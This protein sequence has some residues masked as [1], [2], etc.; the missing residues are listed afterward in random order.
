MTD[1]DRTTPVP[2]APARE[3]DGGLRA[4]APDHCAAPGDDA[5]PTGAADG[6]AD[7]TD[8]VGP[9]AA[10]S[11]DSVGPVLGVPGRPRRDGA[12]P[13]GT[14]DDAGSA[15]VAEAAPGASA[16]AG[17]TSATAAGASQP[18]AAPDRG[19]A[20]P[21][22]AAGSVPASAAGS[23]ADTTDPVGPVL[24]VPDLALVVLVGPSGS[25]KSVFAA[26]HFL[27]TEVV[28]SDRCRAAV[29]D[30]PTDQSATPDAFALLDF[31]VRTRLRRG[32]LT[33]VDATSVQREARAALLRAAKD[34]DVPAAAIVF[35]VPES[36]SQA[37]NAERTD[38]APV[39]P[40][41]VTRQARDLRRGLKRLGKE[42]FRRVHVLRGADEADAARVVRERSWND[43]KDLTGPFD[44]IGDVHGCRAEL[45]ELLGEL[46][47]TVHR[48][49]DGRAVG[50]RHP[51]GRTAV[52]VGDL[53]DR[54]PD[55]PGVLRLA[56]G[57]VGDGDA[58]CVSGNHEN[59]LV[60]ALR[61]RK[62]STGHGLA[63]SLDQLA[64]AGAEFTA[65][66][67]DFC[68]G[69]I[70][71]Y[72]LDGGQLVVA[73]AGLKEEYH[74]RASGR[75]RSFALYGE[76]TGETDDLGLP[77]RLDWAQEYRGAAAVVYGHVPTASATWVNNTICL[78]TGC[79]FG[80]RLTALRYPERTLVGVEAHRTWYAPP[81]PLAAEPERTGPA[82]D[83]ADV[84]ADA[85]ADGRPVIVDTSYAPVR[86][87]PE[88][89]LAAL[90]SMSRFGADPRWLIYL[91][92][93]M[94]PAPTS[95]D[96][97][98]LERPAE[99]FERYRTWGVER[100]IAQEK[101]MGSRA[102]A[103]VCRDAAAAERRFVP[104]QLGAVYTRTGRPFFRDAATEA[105]VL[106]DLR[107]GITAAG[108]WER[109]DTDWIAFDGELLPWS[110]KAGGLIRDHYASV[111]AAARAALP[112][113]AAV[114]DAAVQ[115][116]LDVGGLA[117]RVAEAREDTD[118]FSRV[119]RRYTWPVEGAAG[120]RYAPFSVLAAE[121][122]AFTDRDHRWHMEV[123][124]LL[125]EHC[126]LVRTTRYLEV[127]TGD[128][129]STAAADRWWHSLVDAGGEGIVVKPLAGLAAS[130]SRGLLQP[131]LKVRGPEYLRI[132][133][134]ADYLRPDRLAR[135]RDRKLGR[136]S[137]LA[138]REHTLGVEALARHAA[139]EPVH[140][141][142]QPV[143]AALALEADPVDPRL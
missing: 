40:H 65:R 125:A 27:P 119:Y 32:L 20:P 25:G 41:A 37:R 143:F 74:G 47:Y 105:E 28:S 86:V 123:A 15:G 104:G 97:A 75:V 127:D 46:G 1:D 113:A 112:A 21:A 78:D 126:P 36:L 95:A 80:G 18:A 121:G 24:D 128:P 31:T 124:E 22:G 57:M 55:T 6:S 106:G 82:V 45:E 19:A 63:E 12:L 50:A 49:A 43:R 109:L 62:V 120:L 140:R 114:L 103:V 14:A 88:H 60:R 90:E 68:D 5:G 29:A 70:A 99:A 42:G 110:A 3:S 87:P 129:E 142:H 79:V 83:A 130:G 139:G 52:F 77:V 54:G 23:A 141:V 76:T 135:L 134:G 94:A 115:R 11:V 133:Y 122:A 59:K 98:L 17:A 4:S 30:D 35:D 9:S 69:L 100:V 34:H 107:A 71:H 38:R 53:V 26:R 61:G 39:P 93:T 118:A 117:A 51:E 64:A 16:D 102:V 131:G 2:N 67:R 33:V 66:A 8:P 89:V 137:G 136:K 92:P 116:G 108:L 7:T 73:H 56:M 101:H 84:G 85:V 111:G 91:P 48:D 96:P 10:G 132:I 58:L 13:A 81:R 72:V 138:L 44:I